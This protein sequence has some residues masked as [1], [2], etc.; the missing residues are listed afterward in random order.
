M[1][2]EPTRKLKNAAY[3]QYPRKELGVMG[4]SMRTD[5]YRYTEW[6]EP[7]ADPVG[8]ELYDLQ[9]DPKGNTNLAGWPAT[10]EIVAEMHR[11][12]HAG[13]QGALPEAK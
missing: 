6:A 4:Y 11:I 5:R 13:W 10:R 7:G 9:T 8:I 3:S 2:E 1:L 12:L